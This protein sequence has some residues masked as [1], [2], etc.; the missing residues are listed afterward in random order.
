MRFFVTF[1]A[2]LQLT[3]LRMPDTQKPKTALPPVPNHA[4]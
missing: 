2:F 3:V 1:L 4:R